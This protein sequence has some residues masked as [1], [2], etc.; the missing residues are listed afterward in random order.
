[1]LFPDWGKKKTEDE[2][3]AMIEAAGGFK[4]RT[5]LEK[6]YGF[7]LDGTSTDPIVADSEA[8]LVKKVMAQYNTF[9]E[10]VKGQTIIIKNA[11]KEGMQHNTVD[12]S[13]PNS[14]GQDP[15]WLRNTLS[16]YLNS[17]WV[18]LEG[19]G[20]DSAEEYGIIFV[21]KSFLAVLREIICC[22]FPRKDF[23]LSHR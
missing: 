5:D 4:K 3:R 13:L 12:V 8:E 21:Q 11:L 1:M 19:E 10:Q 18:V 22:L 23:Y 17:N 6:P 7:Y 9:Q 15:A 2:V 16:K 20:Y 14:H